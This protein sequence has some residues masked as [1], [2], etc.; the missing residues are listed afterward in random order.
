M[1]FNISIQKNMNYNIKKLK[2]KRE[3]KKKLNNIL[4]FFIGLKL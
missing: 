1:Y 4:L 2:L 3:S